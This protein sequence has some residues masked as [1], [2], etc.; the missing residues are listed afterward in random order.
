MEMNS[1]KPLIQF[2]EELSF[3]KLNIKSSI[4]NLNLRISL[5]NS[6]RLLKYR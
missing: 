2:S 1:Y 6:M 5:V 4:N 3:K